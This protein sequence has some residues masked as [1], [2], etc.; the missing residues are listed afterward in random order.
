M[1]HTKAGHYKLISFIFT[2]SKFEEVAVMKVKF[3]T[4]A[5]EG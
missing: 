3:M 4:Q 2:E 1:T 5:Y